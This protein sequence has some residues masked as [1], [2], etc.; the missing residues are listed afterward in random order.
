MNYKVYTGIRGIRVA[1]LSLLLAICSIPAVAQPAA[2]VLAQIKTG[3]E[4]KEYE[5][6]TLASLENFSLAKIDTG[7]DG[8]G[9]WNGMQLVPKGFFYL[10]RGSV[11][12]RMVDPAGCFYFNKLLKVG[13]IRS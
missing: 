10:L 4:W 13:Y 8:F 2:K 5:T 7:V 9:G 11:R 12:W 6:C 3:Q 1:L